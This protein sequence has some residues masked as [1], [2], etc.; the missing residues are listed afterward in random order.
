MH[1]RRMLQELSF[2]QSAAFGVKMLHVK[3]LRM[4]KLLNWISDSASV[5]EGIIEGGKGAYNSILTIFL[6]K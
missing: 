5:H 4:S 2:L 6:E 3:L 1:L